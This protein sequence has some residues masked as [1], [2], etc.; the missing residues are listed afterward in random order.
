[1]DLFTRRPDVF[2]AILDRTAE[3][4]GRYLA[5]TTHAERVQYAHSRRLHRELERTNLALGLPACVCVR[6]SEP[7]T[8]PPIL[9]VPRPRPTFERL[10]LRWR[11]PPSPDLA[12]QLYRTCVTSKGVEHWRVTGIL[13]GWRPGPS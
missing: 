2:A 12:P 11:W 10:P 9:P 5:R 1:M 4:V 7:R 6:I 8:P 13:P 3:K